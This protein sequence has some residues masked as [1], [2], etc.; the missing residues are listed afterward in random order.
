MRPQPVLATPLDIRG[1]NVHFGAAS[2]AAATA[3][4][5]PDFARAHATVPLGSNRIST[6]TI[7]ARFRPLPKPDSLSGPMCS[8][9]SRIFLALRQIT[10]SDRPEVL[11][12]QQGTEGICAATNPPAKNIANGIL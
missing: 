5:C 12:L 3:I 1:L 7:P 10:S 9:W 4:G 2:I 8:T 6:T 11:Q